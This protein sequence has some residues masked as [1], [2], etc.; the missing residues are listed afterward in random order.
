MA[1]GM[2]IVDENRDCILILRRRRLLSVSKSI[3]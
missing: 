3:S 2:K 1:Q